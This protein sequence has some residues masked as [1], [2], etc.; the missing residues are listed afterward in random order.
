MFSHVFDCIRVRSFCVH[1][2]GKERF[3]TDV[4]KYLTNSDVLSVKLY[5]TI[6]TL[7]FV[8]V[9]ENNI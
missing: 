7:A 1:L 3:A 2:C 8:I 4:E 5:V 9:K 6:P